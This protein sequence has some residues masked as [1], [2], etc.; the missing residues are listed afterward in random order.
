MINPLIVDILIKRIELGWINPKTNLP[1]TVDDI[2][3]DEYKNA[4]YE[5]NVNK[6]V[7]K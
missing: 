4:V 3:I 1:L 7:I 5:K 6:G 2:L